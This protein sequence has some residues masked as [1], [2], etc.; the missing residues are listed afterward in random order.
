[1]NDQECKTRQAITNI[2]SNERYSIFVNKFSGRCNTI[3][4]AYSK[5]CAPDVVKNMNIKVINL[6]SRINETRQVSW[7]ETCRCKRRL[8]PS[9][10]NNKQH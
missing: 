8:D 5:L 6:L 7:H 1:M 4:D 9:V 2:N 3:N 10:C